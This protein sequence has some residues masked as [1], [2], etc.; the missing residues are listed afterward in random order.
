MIG[1]E[2]EV[3]V[4]WNLAVALTQ[5]LDFYPDFIVVVHIESQ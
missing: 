3:V 1:L 5:F 2:Y 4:S